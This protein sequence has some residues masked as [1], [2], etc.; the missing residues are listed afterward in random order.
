MK[1]TLFCPKCNT[2][3]KDFNKTNSYFCCKCKP[4]IGIYNICSGIF[5]SFLINDYNFLKIEFSLSIDNERDLFYKYHNYKKVEKFII[6]KFNN[7][8]DFEYSINFI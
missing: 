6:S 3:L 5:I 4:I 1:Y 7:D 8:Y 2:N